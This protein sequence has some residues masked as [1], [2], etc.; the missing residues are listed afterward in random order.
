MTKEKVMS[1]IKKYYLAF[2]IITCSIILDQLTKII[3]S[4]NLEYTIGENE[5]VIFSNS[6]EII[7]DF[8]YFTYARNTGAG[9]SIL[10][11]EMWLLILITI[12]SL[13]IFVY[14]LKDF[15][16]K[17]FPFASIGVALMLGGTLGNFIDRLSQGFVVDF[18]DF[19]IFG[20]DFPIFNVADI[21][22]V[23][24]AIML[25]FQVI[26]SKEF[27]LEIK[28]DDKTSENVGGEI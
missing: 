6:V 27:F 9:W 16:L 13:G 18:F 17:K 2:I 10:S 20:Y 25:V 12:V 26:V 1:F 11:G 24:G 8:F 14:L 3:A 5:K 15:N 21:C 19:I 7:K 4:N 23:V 28:K 22:L